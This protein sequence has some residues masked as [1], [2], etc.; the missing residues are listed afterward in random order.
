MGKTG[1]EPVTFCTTQAQYQMTTHNIKVDP[2][3]HSEKNKRTTS[4]KLSWFSG[5]PYLLVDLGLYCIYL[6]KLVIAHSKV[7][8]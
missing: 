7:I 2:L 4:S 1:L 6:Y 5:N 8:T 3:S